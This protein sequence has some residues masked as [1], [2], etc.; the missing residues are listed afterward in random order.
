MKEKEI[1]DF[2]EKLNFSNGRYDSRDIFRDVISL[3]V[4]VIQIFMLNNTDYMEDYN[5]ILRKYTEEEQLQLKTIMKD[6]AELYNKQYEITDLLTDIF[7]KLGISNKETGQFFTP[8]HIS[9]LAVKL[10]GINEDEIKQKGYITLHE[11]ATGAGGMILAYANELKEK[12][13]NPS[14]NLYVVACDIDIL[15]TYMT[16]LQLAMYDIPA[17][18]VNGDTLTLKE[19]FVLYTPQYFRGFWNLKDVFSKEKDKDKKPKEQKAS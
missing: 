2:I 13:F 3:L 1:K 14:K 5:N 10:T 8:F 18:V 16:Y 12:G 15:C 6:L 19:H 4:F 9:K 17:V 11:P 7:E